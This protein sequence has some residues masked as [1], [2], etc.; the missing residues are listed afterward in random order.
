[1]IVLKTFVFLSQLLS[2]DNE[3]MGDKDATF[4]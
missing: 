3:A 2:V 1:M 4:W